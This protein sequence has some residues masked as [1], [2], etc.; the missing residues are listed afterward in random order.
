MTHR[1][2]GT[3]TRSSALRF[4]STFLP[5]AISVAEIDS[6]A[7]PCLPVLDVVSSTMWHG[8]S[9]CEAR[10]VTVCDI[11]SNREAAPVL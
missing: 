2:P 6:L 7:C 10:P 11:G 4:R 5:L 3:V 8:S 9:A 1:F